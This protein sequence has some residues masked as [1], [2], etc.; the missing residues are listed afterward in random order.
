[1]SLWDEPF[2]ESDME[3]DLQ[4]QVDEMD[5]SAIVILGE[6]ECEAEEGA[7]DHDEDKTEE[8]GMPH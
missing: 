4:V 2:Y 8:D 3:A 6:Q 1:M 5:Q 7:E